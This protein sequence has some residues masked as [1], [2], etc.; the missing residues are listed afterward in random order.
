MPRPLIT[1]TT[2]FGHGSPYVAQMKGVILA[3]C[4]EVDLVDITHAIGPQNV[5]EGAVVLA[6]ATPRFPPGTIHVAVVDPGVGTSRR[7]VFAEIGG[8]R[9]LAPD[10]GL[11][12]LLAERNPPQRL[13]ALQNAAYWGPEPSR[14]FHGRDI[15]APVAGNLARGVDPTELGPPLDSLELLDWSKPKRAEDA[16]HGEVLYLDFF[17]NI[18][19]NID[20]PLIESLGDQAR[21]SIS[22]GGRLVSGMVTT[23][24]NAAPGKLVALFD[25][26]DRLEVAIVQGNAAREL[27]IAPGAPVRVMRGP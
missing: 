3:L 7:L 12:S 21:L 8:Q 10:N 19:T 17:G 23:Y 24:A 1:L 16:V 25:S 13:R 11:L 5:R 9:Y 20:R 15:L 26:Q 6:D 4:R 18:I 22:C 27:A 14:T 2:D